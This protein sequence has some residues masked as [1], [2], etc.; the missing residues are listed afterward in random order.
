MFGLNAPPSNTEA[1]LQTSF[2]RITR[3]GSSGSRVVLVHGSA[4]GSQT[5]GDSH[6]SAQQ[7]LS[8]EGFQLL[9]PDRPG[10]GRSP[11]RGLPDDAALDGAWV[12][13]LLGDAAHLVGHSFG[14][15][16]ALEAAARR[17][18]AMLSVT[19]IEPALQ[20]LALHLPSVRRFSLQLLAV[21]WLSL[22]AASRARRF[23][24]LAGIP[25]EINN[26]RSEEELKRMGQGI[27]RLQLPS[28]TTMRLQ[29]QALRDAG[30]PLLVVTGGWSAAIDGT[31]A[32]A[33][34]L[35]GG[36][37]RVVK[38]PHHFPNLLADA[39]NPLLLNF[40]R[41]SEAARQL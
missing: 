11:S 40:L 1:T 28:P 13:N 20:K 9:V 33:A 16:V 35:G 41:D 15:C 14:A 7:A 39:F 22:S 32:V 29:L 34:E 27:A 23:A 3:W 12:A 31:G 17:P 6:F 19:L 8:A 4:Q 36:Q 37:H 26:A 30:I 10:H 21:K 18:R 2:I 38:A 25:L 24:R 5:G